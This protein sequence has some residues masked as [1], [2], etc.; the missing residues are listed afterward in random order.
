[1]HTN[2]RATQAT[3]AR[4]CRDTTAQPP[5]YIHATT[6]MHAGVCVSVCVSAMH[7]YEI[8]S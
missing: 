1:M 4:K 3:P 5:E 2:T 6:D 8:I 7:I